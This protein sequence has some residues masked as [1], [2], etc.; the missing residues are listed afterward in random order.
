MRKTQIG[1]GIGLTPAFETKLN[2]TKGKG[3][4]LPASTRRFMENAFGSD[5]SRVRLHTGTKAAEIGRV[6]QAR[7]FTHDRDIYFN[8]G[9]FNPRREEGKRLLAHELTHVM[10]QTGFSPAYNGNNNDYIQCQGGT[11]GGFF[12]NIGR[13]IASIFG[14]EPEFDDEDIQAYLAIFECR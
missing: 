1:G 4:P 14:D 5:F 6:I 8:C 11:F 9:E 10:Q 12:R 2:A 7:A 13:G 3:A